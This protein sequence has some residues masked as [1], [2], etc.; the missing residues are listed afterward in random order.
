MPQHPVEGI[1][2]SGPIL[3][4]FVGDKPSVAVRAPVAFVGVKPVDWAFAARR[5]Q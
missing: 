2:E 4:Q 1:L 5:P 3:F